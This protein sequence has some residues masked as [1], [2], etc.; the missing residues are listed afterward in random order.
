MFGIHLGKRKKGST[1]L[2][3]DDYYAAYTERYGNQSIASRREID[4]ILASLKANDK[5]VDTDAVVAAMRTLVGT[6]TGTRSQ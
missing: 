3:Y 6:P 1:D 4:Q 5:P 2:S